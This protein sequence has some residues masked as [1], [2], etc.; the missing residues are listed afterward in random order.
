[1]KDIKSLIE[2]SF[3][4]K[5]DSYE[6]IYS[7][8]HTASDKTL[9]LIFQAIADRGNGWGTQNGA[10]RKFTCDWLVKHRFDIPTGELNIFDAPSDWHGR[11]L[12]A[13][14]KICHIINPIR[15]PLIWDS[16]I[17]AA[18]GKEN[19]S[20]TESNW[21]ENVKAFVENHPELKGERSDDNERIWLAESTIWANNDLPT[22]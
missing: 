7:N 4:W 6:V 1:M 21:N 11:Q 17:R 5:K 20:V 14:S 2:N 16:H 10:V 9:S 18:M 15:Y 8:W 19:I 22:T 12:S 13:V 3:N